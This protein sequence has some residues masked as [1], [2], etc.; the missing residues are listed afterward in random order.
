MELFGIKV[1]KSS[2]KVHQINQTNE[3]IANQKESSEKDIW[4]VKFIEKVI[5]YILLVFLI[6]I[7]I[8]QVRNF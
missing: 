7:C 3:K 5:H 6:V 2:T 8:Y 1:S 4:R